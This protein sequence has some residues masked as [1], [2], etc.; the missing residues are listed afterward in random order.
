MYTTIRF[1]TITLIINEDSI[2]LKT[3]EPMENTVKVRKK[4][5]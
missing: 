4:C 3:N 1:L 2:F 5:K